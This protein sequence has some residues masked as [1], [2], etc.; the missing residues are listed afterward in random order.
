M[1][2]AAEGSLLTRAGTAL[3]RSCKEA[4]LDTTGVTLLR[5]FANTV[6]RLEGEGVVVRLAQATAP[7]KLD[8]LTTSVRVTRWLVEQGFPTI[9]PL[10]VK[11]PVAAEGFLATFWRHE[12]HVGPPP[13]PAQLGPLLRRLHDLP[14][15]PFELP[16]HD[17]FGPVRRAIDAAL[18]LG[19]DDRRWLIERCERLSE[20]YYERMEFA[21][22]YGL[23]HAD[24]HR[25]NMIRTRDGFLLCDW[26]GVCAGPREVDLIPTLQGIRFGLTERQRSNFSEAYGYD[27]TRWEGYPVLRDMRELQTLTA[28]LRNAHRDRTAR[29]E[30][31]HRLGSLRAGDDR[32]WHP[33]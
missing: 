17:P 8:R 32:L 3:I 2:V 6:Y 33:L 19:E 12:E 26:D 28:V 31:T 15:V 22:P 13:D 11:Q 14:P 9:R 29:D 18:S 24:A 1:T 20:I 7:G 5:D 27:A 10:E 21:L 23:I 4:G 30:L 16:T 25:G